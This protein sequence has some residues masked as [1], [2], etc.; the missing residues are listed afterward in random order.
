MFTKQR[1]FAMAEWCFLAAIAFLIVRNNEYPW[2]LKRASDIFIFIS[3]LATL[4]AY[5]IPP[6]APLPKFSKTIVWGIL[7][8]C[9]GG[10]L[11]EIITLA[12]H[13]AS[14]S[15]ENILEIFRFGEVISI[16]FLSGVLLS[17]NSLFAKKAAV[18]QLS[19]L[20]Y[21]IVFF[22]PDYFATE[23]YRFQLFENWPSNIGYYLIASIT[24]LFIWWL[25]AFEEKKRKTAI[26]TYLGTV[27]LVAIMLWTQ[28]RASWVGITLVL[29]LIMGTWAFR[30]RANIMSRAS[31]TIA[32][33]FIIIPIL[34]FAILPCYSRNLVIGRISPDFRAYFLD[35]ETNICQPDQSAITEITALQ[36]KNFSVQLSDNHRTKLWTIYWNMLLDR[37]WGLGISYT[38]IDIGAGPQ[39]PHNTPLELLAL[40]GPLGLAGWLMLLGAGIKNIAGRAMRFEHIPLY[41]FASLIGL[42]IASFFDNMSTFRLMW[43]LLSLALFLPPHNTPHSN[44]SEE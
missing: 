9:G 22:S 4:V 30:H 25:I 34:S 24:M 32:I 36:Q 27:V 38:P 7:L 17:R 18:V 33:L 42:F 31:I 11:A 41:L 26:L 28:S 10:A 13:S 1:I 3:I 35:N 39:G 21:A 16:L 6:R 40:T 12:S 20:T 2:V 14:L 29:I 37:P 15:G 43:I 23:M 19:T 44:L 5:R 8:L